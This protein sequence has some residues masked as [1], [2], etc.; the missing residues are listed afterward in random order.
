MRSKRKPI[1]IA[2]LVVI[3]WFGVTGFFGP[4]FGKLTSVQEND[5]SAFLPDSAE[6]TKAV[7]LLESFAAGE[8]TAFP[9][10]VLLEGSV[11]PEVLQQI[12]AH[13]ETVPDLKL[14]GTDVPLSKYLLPGSQVTAFPA[15]DGKAVLASILLDGAA[16]A[17]VLPND[18][19]VLPAIVEAL[20][21]DFTPFAKDLGF[22]S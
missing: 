9:T 17:E 2:I 7:K 12:N 21:E 18:E 11:G 19:P 15:P 3:A 10:L 13:L 1:A 14:G 16:I 5:N 4:L 20:R 8:S 22:D 6:S